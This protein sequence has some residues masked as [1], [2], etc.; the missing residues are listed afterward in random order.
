MKK[1]NELEKFNMLHRLE[2]NKG[3]L[4]EQITKLYELQAS[5]FNKCVKT[6]CS[7]HDSSF[8]ST[9]N[10]AILDFEGYQPFLLSFQFRIWIYILINLISPHKLSFDDFQDSHN[11][12]KT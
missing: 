8:L 5:S 6:L 2:S 3:I 9:L 1:F 7:I 11:H 4:D 10:A 12:K